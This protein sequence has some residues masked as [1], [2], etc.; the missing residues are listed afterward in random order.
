MLTLK[1]I[2][3]ICV[4]RKRSVTVVSLAKEPTLN[5]SSEVIFIRNEVTEMLELS[6]I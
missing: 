5:Y 1:D 4:V 2:K 6:V 3:Y